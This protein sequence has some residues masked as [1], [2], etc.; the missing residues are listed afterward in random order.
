MM[1]DRSL[2]ADMT[3]LQRQV[4]SGEI[5]AALDAKLPELHALQLA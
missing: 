3:A 1:Q 5:A 4:F 2:S